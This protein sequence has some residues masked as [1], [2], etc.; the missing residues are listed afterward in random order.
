IPFPRGRNLTPLRLG[1]AADGS[2]LY[3]DSDQGVWRAAVPPT[4]EAAAE[5]GT[6]ELAGADSALAIGLGS[7]VFARAEPCDTVP[8]ALCAAAMAGI[9]LLSREA[10]HPARWGTDS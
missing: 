3:I 5:V 7:P 6:A 10:A 4:G 1:W 2:V 9:T 8:G